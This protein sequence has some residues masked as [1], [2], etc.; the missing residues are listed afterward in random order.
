MID[1]HAH[2]GNL[3]REGYPERPPLSAQQLVDR[4]DREGIDLAVLLP[5][6]SPE[7]GWGYLLTEEAVAARNLYPERFIAFLCVDPRY[8]SA[9]KFIDFQVKVHGCKGL[10]EHVNGLAFDDPLNKVIYAKCDEHALPLDF[11]INRDLCWDEVGLP[12]LEK[13][14]K[15]F[16]NVTFVGH[17]PGFWS[18]IS[19]DDPRGSY[20]TDPVKPGGAVDRLLAEYDN[21]YADLSAGSGYNAMTRDPE[22]TQGFLQRHWRKLLFGTDIVFVNAKLPIVEWMKTVDVTDEM[23]EAMAHGNS[24]RLLG[25][26]E[27]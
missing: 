4:M 7:G 25:L 6:E 21:M 1:F 12:R 20:P 11:E 10:G 2:M 19:A 5:L 15:E 23:R 9:A 17:G 16:P 3:G 8:P 24:A 14:L 13:C 22:F 18:A 26:D 27:E